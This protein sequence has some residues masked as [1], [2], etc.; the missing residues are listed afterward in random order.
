MALDRRQFVEACSSLGLTGVLPGLLYAEV[1]DDDEQEIT[2]EHV[3]AA[4][5]IAG[6]SFTEEERALLVE[7][8]N[9]FLE[10]YEEMRAHDVPNSRAPAFTFDP[11]RG[12]AAV[13]D[14]SAEADGAEVPLPDAERPSSDEDLAFASIPTLAALLRDREVTSVE[15]TERALERLRR[16]DPDL[17]AVITYTEER[18]LE[19]ARRADQELDAGTW[20]GPLHGVPYGAKDLLAV[21]GYKTTWG[22]EPYRR[23]QID[24]TATVVEKLDEAGA[25]LV[26]K[27]SLGALAWGDVWYDAT[28]KNPWNLDQGSSG[29]SAGPAAAVSAG[30]VP[31]A[32][33]SETL[34]SIVSPSTRTGITG[35]RPTF[36]AVSR[37]GA[38]TLSWS[39]DKLGPMA[40]SAVDCGL[41]YDA[42]RGADAGDPA[43][44]DVP[45]PFA[46][47]TDPTALRVGYARAAFENDYDNK[48]ADHSTLEVLRDRGVD[49]QPVALP[50]DLPVGALLGT[51]DVEAATAFDALTR[52]DRI[53][54][55]VR[56]GEDTWPNVFRS[57]RFVPGVEFLQMNRL[58]VRLME[59]MH[60]VMADLDVLV[61]PSF[62]GGVLGITNL[63]GHPCVCL[64][65]A[66]RPVEEGPDSRR[67]PGSISLIGPLYRDAAPLTLAHALQQATDFHTRRPPIE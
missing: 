7:N 46:P 52:S 48:D 57:A 51:L 65:N 24:E 23:Q 22:A 47:S 67:Q 59:Q 30:C 18:A 45:F 62:E 54:E 37:D 58:R 63:T 20:R 36:G 56:Q 17:N 42:L 66:F 10:G 44:R 25:V 27:L 16:Y 6:L 40:R 4:E 38:M 39:M 13:P 50:S 2:T 41:V 19:A 3:A 35:H 8:L 29:S 11:R 61:T 53:D 55:L 28:T 64:P 32:I 14:V 34:G 31:F 21:E 49:L 1:V 12:G 26:A 60:A 5:T 43:S 9:E 15:L 33:G